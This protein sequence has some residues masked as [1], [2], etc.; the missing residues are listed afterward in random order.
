MNFFIQFFTVFF[1]TQTI[2][3]IRNASKHFSCISVHDVGQAINMSE[4]CNCYFSISIFPA[5][6][7]VL[8]EVD[9]MA[10]YKKDS[11]SKSQHLGRF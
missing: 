2:F 1:K 3:T 10:G 4:I 6:G 7:T 8:F 9:K 11:R 5:A